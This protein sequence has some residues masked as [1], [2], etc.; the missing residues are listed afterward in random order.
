[1]FPLTAVQILHVLSYV[2]C[3]HPF[4][5]SPLSSSP[6][7]PTVHTSVNAYKTCL[8]LAKLWLFEDKVLFCNFLTR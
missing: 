6:E 2:I 3:S 4:L 5:L 8:F 7:S 1:M